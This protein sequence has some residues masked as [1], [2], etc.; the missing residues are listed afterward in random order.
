VADI[1]GLAASLGMA[2][3]GP[4]AIAA[5][6]LLLLFGRRLYWLFAGIV[7]FAAVFTVAGRLVPELS[8][9]ATLFVALGAGAIGAVVTIFAHKVLLGIV[10]GL[11]GALIAL[12]QVQSF[13]VERGLEWLVAAVVGGLIG[14][15]LVSRVFEFALALLSS[16]V[17]AQLLLDAMTVRATW[18]LPAYIGL[19]V[20]GL[21]FQLIRSKGGK[22]ERR[23][24]G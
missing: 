15:W 17:G 18:V 3:G 5:G 1:S 7:G 14:A 6:L 9:Q 19:V 16:L 8:S 21:F 11:A 2:L 22:R 23:R 13:G 10:G 4:L 12:W 24:K 20:F